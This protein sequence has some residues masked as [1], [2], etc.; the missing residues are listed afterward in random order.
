MEKLIGVRRATASSFA[1]YGHVVAANASGRVEP[2]EAALDL[3]GGRPRFYIMR[4]E[5]RGRR[6]HSIARHCRVTQCLASVG[7]HPWLLGVAPPAGLDD[8]EAAPDPD[9]IVG[10][11]IPGDVYVMLH[12]GTWHAGPYF[13]APRVDFFNLELDDTNERDFHAVDLQA[14]FG[15]TF[16]F[17][18]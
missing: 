5:A 11:E 7:G 18:E 8:P 17:A 12:K 14:R 2:G 1:P 6:F 16:R 10:F 15:V 9:A 4:L 3:A 13:D